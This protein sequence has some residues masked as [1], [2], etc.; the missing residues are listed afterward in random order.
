MLKIC[1]QVIVCFTIAMRVLMFFS[2]LR[3]LWRWD[4]RR[5]LSLAAQFRRELGR[6]GLLLPVPEIESGS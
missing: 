1:L 6:R 3:R 2:H 5:D 4:G